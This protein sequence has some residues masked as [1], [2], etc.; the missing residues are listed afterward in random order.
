[1]PWTGLARADEPLSEAAFRRTPLDFV[2]EAVLRWDGDV[3][4]QLAFDPL[5]LGWQTDQGTVPAGL[6][7]VRV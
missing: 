4:G 3:A 5:A 6:A 2:G 1:M 7:L